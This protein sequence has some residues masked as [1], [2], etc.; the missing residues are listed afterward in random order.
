M[1]KLSL[2]VRIVGIVALACLF[3]AVISISGFLYF[4]AKAVDNGIIN[5][6]ETI[7]TQLSAATSYVAQQ[8]GLR[9]VIKTYQ[10]KY[11]S[12]DRLTEADKTEIL[13]Q[14][15]IYA[16]MTIGRQNQEKDHYSFRVFSD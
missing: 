6:A 2:K 1:N 15:P 14:V 16:A 12:A 10:A 9:E 13:K 3:G 4:N 8:G 5:K 7:H 11:K